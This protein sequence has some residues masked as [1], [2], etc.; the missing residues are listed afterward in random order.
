MAT[1]TASSNA[2]AQEIRKRFGRW[3]PY[4]VTVEAVSGTLRYRHYYG[5]RKDLFDASDILHFK[6]LTL[7]GII[8]LSVIGMAR[9]G[10][11]V[12]LAQQTH[13]GSLFKNQARPSLVM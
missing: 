9:Q 13:A 8:G 3:W 12:A 7:D 4:G 6:G 10:I 1:S 5:G 2:T 11:G